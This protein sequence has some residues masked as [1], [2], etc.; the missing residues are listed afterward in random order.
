MTLL[1]RRLFILL[2]GLL[3]FPAAEP[4]ANGWE[5]GAI[6]F[7][8]LVAALKQES[9]EI[10]LKAVRS[11]GFRG[12]VEGVPP[13]LKLLARPDPSRRVRAA[14]DESRVVR[15]AA[16]YAVELLEAPR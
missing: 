7:E 5:H 3:L 14:H 11:L 13:L 10:R 4:R 15:E 9:S 12:Q 1:P 16:A 8:A 2:F 6:P